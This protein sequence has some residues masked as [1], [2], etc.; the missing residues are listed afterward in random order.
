MVSDP[1]RIWNM[2]I[3]SMLPICVNPILFTMVT[4]R[5]YPPVVSWFIIPI[6]YRYKPPFI[7]PSYWTDVHQLSDS[8]LGHHLVGG[9]GVYVS[10]LERTCFLGSWIYWGDFTSL[11]DTDTARMVALNPAPLGNNILYTY[12]IIHDHPWQ[13]GYS[14]CQNY[15]T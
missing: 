9:G 7:N 2:P 3:E 15:R 10:L 11:S 8:E 6:N 1:S 4:A 5:W 14:G 13:Y 12:M